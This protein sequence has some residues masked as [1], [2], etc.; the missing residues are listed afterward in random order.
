MK[1]SFGYLGVGAMVGTGV[2]IMVGIWVGL[3]VGNCVGYADV[4][5][6]N[7]GELEGKLVVGKKVELGGKELVGCTV[8]NM[9]GCGVGTEGAGDG[10]IVGKLV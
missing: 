10:M 4:E 5:G 8:G 2:G 1:L 9:L 3:D 7:V 6:I